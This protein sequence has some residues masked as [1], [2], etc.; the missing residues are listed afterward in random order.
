MAGRWSTIYSR[1]PLDVDLTDQEL[2][3]LEEP[4]TPHGVAGFFSGG[5]RE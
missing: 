1:R 3:L 5:D 4:C 2:A